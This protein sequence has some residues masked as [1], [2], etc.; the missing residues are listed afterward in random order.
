M[1]LRLVACALALSGPVGPVLI[2]RQESARFADAGARELLHRS[3]A[4]VAHE[5]SPRD[6]RSFLFKGRVRVPQ[7]DVADSHED[8]QVEIRILLPDRYLRIDTSGGSERRS[9]VAGR[10]PLP[11]GGPGTPGRTGSPGRPGS[12][13]RLERARL[14]R[15]LLGAVAYGVVAPPLLFRSTGETAFAD[16]A[17][18]DVSGPDL[19]ARL[20]FDAASNIPLRLVY[21]GDRGVSTVVSFANRR[22]VSGL[23]LPFRITT[24]TPERV[25]E[26]LLFDD[27]FVNPDLHDG[28][29]RR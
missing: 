19:S 4:A 24:Q 13:V 26:T 8:G 16:T 29:F 1:M 12:D 14:M 27:I 22:R 7:D 5:G 10:A 15:I 9:G 2:A 11:P 28:D 21:V 25:L 23:D 6:L 20:V 17:A 18:L 3:Q